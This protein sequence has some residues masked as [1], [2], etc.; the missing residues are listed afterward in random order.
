MKILFLFTIFDLI[1]YDE[2]VFGNFVHLINNGT[3]HI[4]RDVNIVQNRL[5]FYSKL[6]SKDTDV[7]II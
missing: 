2:F 1:L 6:K 4:D 5:I 3:E 7:I